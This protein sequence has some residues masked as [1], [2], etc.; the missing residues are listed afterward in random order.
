MQERIDEANRNLISVQKELRDLQECLETQQKQTEQLMAVNK[1]AVQIE[2]YA[3]QKV[4]DAQKR[5]GTAERLARGT[6]REVVKRQV[7]TFP[8]D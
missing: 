7:P 2:Q 6:A 3:D 8:D 1:K 5:A 4:W